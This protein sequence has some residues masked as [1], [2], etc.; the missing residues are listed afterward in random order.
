LRGVRGIVYSVVAAC[1]LCT[2]GCQCCFLKPVVSPT[3]TSAGLP[4]KEILPI[5]DKLNLHGARVLEIRPGP[6]A[7]FWEVG[8]ENNGR[9]F[10]IYVDSSKK[11]V[12]PGPF[13][14]YANRRDITRE[15]TEELNRDRR[16]DVSMLPL[17]DALTVGRSDAPTRVVVFTD[18]DCSYCARLHLEMKKLVEKRPD[19]VFFLKLFVMVSRDAEKA[20]SIV[21]GKSLRMLEDAYEHKEVPKSDCTTKE[22]DGNKAFADSNGIDAAPALIFPDGSLQTGFS[23][24]EALERSIDRAVQRRPTEGK[25]DQ[26]K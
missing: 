12:T 11:Y 13:I 26:P 20:K 9:R 4:D 2:A 23:N 16:V 7:G 15:R 5:L 10:V 24:A 1:V 22:L 19:I 6:V 18:P 8:V 21:C 25:R 3:Q 17:N 14:D